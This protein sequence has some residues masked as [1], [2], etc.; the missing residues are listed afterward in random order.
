[1][2][3]RLAGPAGWFPHQAFDHFSWIPVMGILY[4]VPVAIVVGLA[5]RLGRERLPIGTR[6]RGR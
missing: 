4:W 5:G 6:K 1:M 2:A 3:G